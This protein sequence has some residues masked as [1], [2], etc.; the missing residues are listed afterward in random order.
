MKMLGKHKPDI[1]DRYTAISVFRDYFNLSQFFD[2]KASIAVLREELAA[3]GWSPNHINEMEQVAAA[4]TVYESMIPHKIKEQGDQRAWR[5]AKFR[6][7]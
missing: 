5:D 1:Y 7:N 6:S 4:R 3:I 2:Y